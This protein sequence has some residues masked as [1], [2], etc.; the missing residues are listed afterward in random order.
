MAEYKRK[1]KEDPPAVAMAAAETGNTPPYAPEMEEA[2][3][4]AMM[5]EDDCVFQAM[6]KLFRERS[7]V[8]MIPSLSICAKMVRW[9]RSA[10]SGYARIYDPA[11]SF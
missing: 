7:A 5:V 6:Q 3:I 10:E 4:G 8:D 9:T 11:A 1:R 2:V